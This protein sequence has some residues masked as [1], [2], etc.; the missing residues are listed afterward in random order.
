MNLHNRKSEENRVD[1]AYLLLE[2]LLEGDLSSATLIS[3]YNS[4]MLKT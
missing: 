2:G 3:L 4:D 1:L